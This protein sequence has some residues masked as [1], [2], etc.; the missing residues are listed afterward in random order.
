MAVTQVVSQDMPVHELALRILG[1]I[2]SKDAQRM[3]EILKRGSVVAGAS[4]LRWDSILADEREVW[5]ALSS[6]P[7]AEPSRPFDAGRCVEFVLIE[8][9]R[10]VAIDVAAAVK[11]GWFQR[12]SFWDAV[13]EATP[14]PAY[15]DYSYKDSAD[16]YR[17]VLSTGQN[18]AI[19]DGL[20]LLPFPVRLTAID[21]IEFLVPRA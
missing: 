6:F 21:T 20:R 16:V 9:R 13:M 3:Q 15:H 12:R 19:Q 10:R 2:G 1:V 5:E 4:R 14:H 7:D 17:A 11:R 18:S 8:G